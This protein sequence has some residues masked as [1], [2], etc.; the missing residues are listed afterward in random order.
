MSEPT[1]KWVAVIAG[2]SL[3]WVATGAS[4][5]DFWIEP[6]TFQPQPGERVSVGLCI[7]DP[8]AGWSMARNGARIEQFLAVG[9]TGERPIV[10]VDG[11]DP[12][13]VTRFDAPGFYVLAYRSNDAFTEMQPAKF[14]EYLLE[15]GL[16]T[17]LARRKEQRPSANP[18]REAYARYSKS[19]LRVGDVT[20]EYA[21]RRI[22]FRFE[23]LAEPLAAATHGDRQ[24]A[25]LL[26]FEGQPLPDALVTATRRGAPEMR[27]RTR[28]GVSGRALFSLP[29]AGVW[30]IASVHMVE[31][32]KN[33]AADWESLWASL[34]FEI[35][36]QRPIAPASLTSLATAHCDSGPPALASLPQ[37]V[38]RQ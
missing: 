30:Q 1:R 15:K 16:D 12:A 34:T 19:L 38:P 2:L 6:S 27:I 29:Q 20:G 8:F 21:D 5:H 7:G 3:A 26:L 22:G 32:P 31:A 9:S 11:S 37:P 13:G 14:A 36:S 28:T 4:A 25:F 35:P 18:V 10:G 17:I 24:F 23:L 33:I